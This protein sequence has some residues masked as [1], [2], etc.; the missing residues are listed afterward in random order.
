LVIGH[1]QPVI[2][3]AIGHRVRRSPLDRRSIADNPSR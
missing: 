2:A 3:S 1:R